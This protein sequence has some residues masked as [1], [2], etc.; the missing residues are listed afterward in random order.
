MA[1]KSTITVKSA[2]PPEKVAFWEAH[3]DHPDG[4]V[5]VAGEDDFEIGETANAKRAIRQ[6]RLETV[7]KSTRSKS[8]R[9]G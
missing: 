5:F 9:S 7:N 8:S 4:E 1:K 6:G 3:P 2:L